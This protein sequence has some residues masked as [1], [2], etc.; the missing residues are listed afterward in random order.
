MKYLL[1]LSIF[2][3]GMTISSCKNKAAEDKT[4]PEYTSQYV[5]PMHC[6]GS[7]S[8]QAGTCPVCKMN[9]VLNEEFE[10]QY[11]AEDAH[12]GH[13]HDGHNHDHGHDHGYEGHNH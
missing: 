9:Y 2:F 3:I 4:G 12:D 6:E 7:G 8:D 1:L 10:A 13:N 5:C 11:K